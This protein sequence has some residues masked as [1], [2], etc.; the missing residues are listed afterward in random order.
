MAQRAT[1]HTT[2]PLLAY[3]PQPRR[4]AVVRDTLLGAVATQLLQ[5]GDQ[6]VSLYHRRL[7]HG[8]PTPS[9]ERDAVLAVALPW[10]RDAAGI[11]SRGRFGSYKVCCGKSSGAATSCEGGAVQHVGL[12][13]GDV[14]CE[15]IPRPCRV[16]R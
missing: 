13:H 16:D 10:L 6:V 3:L 14:H 1:S 12:Q 11:W 4:P 8:Y 2:T 15:Y 9:L 5:A 7:E